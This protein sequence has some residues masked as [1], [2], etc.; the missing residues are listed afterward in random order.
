MKLK[1][2]Y[3]PFSLA[4]RGRFRE[5]SRVDFGSKCE[6]EIL[7]IVSSELGVCRASKKKNNKK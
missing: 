2:I 3:Q 5:Y 1:D 7:S 6:L 4:M